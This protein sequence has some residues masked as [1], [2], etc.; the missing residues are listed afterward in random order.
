MDAARQK[1]QKYMADVKKCL[2][3]I[4][5]ASHHLDYLTKAANKL[6]RGLTV[7]SRMI[8]VDADEETEAERREQTR[9]NTLVYME[10]AKHHYCKENC[11][12]SQ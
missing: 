7:E 10:I 4:A 2:I 6:S 1:L 11:T 12:N 9:L 8:L 5:H 3:D